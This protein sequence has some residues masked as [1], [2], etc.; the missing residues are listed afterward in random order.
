MAFS[1]FE[2]MVAWRYL[3]SRRQEGF[4]SIIAGFSLLGI[5]LGVA[6]LIIVMSV[7]GG[8]REELLS[9]ILGMNGHLSVY[10]MGV[11]LEDFDA[12]REKLLPLD[13]VAK[14][15]PLIEGQV[16]A[17]A[18]GVARGAMVHGLRREDLLARKIVADNIQEGS[19]DTYDEGGEVVLGKRLAETLGL[20]IG[21]TVT[22]ISPQGNV[23]A[24]GTVPRLRGYTLGAT[25]EVG[26]F[27]YDSTF[28]FMPLPAAQIFFRLKNKVSGIEVMITDPDQVDDVGLRVATAAGSGKRIYNWKQANSSFFNAIQVERNVMFLILTL[29][30][31]VAAFNIISS[32]IMLVKDKGQ[33]IAILRT[34]GATR[35]MIMRIFFL[36]GAG[37]G[38]TGTIAGF[39]L[40]LAFTAN[41]ETIRGLIERLTGTEL[42]AAEIYFLAHLPVKID[43]TEIVGIVLM[44]LF[45]SVLATLYPSWRAA[46]L[47]P[48]EALRYE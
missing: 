25:F 44:G 19:L 42:F 11:P 23:T 5:A 6:T 34:M 4:I 3:R 26:M 1:S 28:V 47:D 39:A 29:I 43:W 40:G 33:D 31:L 27:E 24:F 22:L 17:T 12:L 37:V 7:M 9:R 21:D 32:L 36:C 30:I 15:T 2:R 13:G 38:I 20:K 16:M 46:R 8:F 35:G 14:A 10:G 45:L 41:I 18:N 48:V